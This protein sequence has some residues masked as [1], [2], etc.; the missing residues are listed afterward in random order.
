MATTLLDGTDPFSVSATTAGQS[1]TLNFTAFNPALGTLTGVEIDI[2]DA[3]AS[4]SGTL[5]NGSGASHTYTISQVATLTAVGDGFNAT[6]DF[7]AGTLNVGS[8]AAHAVAD[9]TSG[10]A[11][12]TGTQ[13]LNSGL[14]PFTSP[15]A[16]MV[17]GANQFV[18]TPGSS[19]IVISP[20]VTG[21]VS[22]Y[23]DYTPAVVIP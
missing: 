6:A 9:I 3:M 2:V 20:D 23:F 7:N 16:L 12:G 10:T 19:T 17:T 11:S 18:S 15:I 21:T 22:L 8:V 13:T 1:Q 14:A 5:T 4:A